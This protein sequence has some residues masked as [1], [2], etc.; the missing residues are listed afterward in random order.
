M[1]VAAYGNF[2]MKIGLVIYTYDHVNTIADRGISTGNI[3]G[4]LFAI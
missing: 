2:I 4:V 1:L 3:C